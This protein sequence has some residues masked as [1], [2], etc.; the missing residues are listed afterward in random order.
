MKIEFY[1]IWYPILDPDSSA[2][3]KIWSGE[4]S[5]GRKLGKGKKVGEKTTESHEGMKRKKVKDKK[6]NF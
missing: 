3:K 4:M 1:K 2:F 6:R 5:E